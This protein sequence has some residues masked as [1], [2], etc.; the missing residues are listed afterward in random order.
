MVYI[1]SIEILIKLPDMDEVIWQVEDKKIIEENYTYGLINKLPI[2]FSRIIAFD[3]IYYKLIDAVVKINVD[4]IN[5][6]YYDEESDV[7]YKLFYIMNELIRCLKAL[8]KRDKYKMRFYIDDDACYYHELLF[9]KQ[10]GIVKCKFRWLKDFGMEGMLQQ[11]IDK[12]GGSEKEVEFS[13]SE[14]FNQI[15]SA[16]NDVNQYFFELYYRLFNQRIDEKVF[17]VYKIH[18]LDVKSL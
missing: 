9:K 10:C 11:Y 17:D 8:R 12:F 7:G 18:S 13:I 4:G 3:D 14:L 1:N 2:K 5:F 15:N 6:V 16:R